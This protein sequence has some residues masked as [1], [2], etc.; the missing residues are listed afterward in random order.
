MQNPQ[1]R[2]MLLFGL[3]LGLCMVCS[4]H[5]ALA[6][7]ANTSPQ[8]FIMGYWSDWNVYSDNAAGRAIPEPAYA[9]PGSMGQSG[10]LANE[11]LQ[12]KLEKI[13]AITYDFLEVDLNGN[14]HF[15]DNWSDVRKNKQFTN[16]DKLFGDNGACTKVPAICTSYRNNDF[17]D[18]LPPEEWAKGNFQAFLNLQNTQHHLQKLISIGGYGHDNDFH[19]AFLHLGNFV[20]SVALL[21]KTTGLDGVDLDF[22]VPAPT[23]QDISDYVSLIQ[24]LRQAL[25]HHVISMAIMAGPDWIKAFG[26]RNWA[27]I[28]ENIDHIDLMTYDFH[29][30]FDTDK[31]RT[32]YLSNLY[33]DPRSSYEPGDF[34]VARSVKTLEAQG[35]PAG[36]IVVGIPAYGRALT[37]VQAEAHEGLFSTFTGIAR[38]DLDA[39]GCSMLPGGNCMG[40]FQYSYIVQHMLAKGFVAHQFN[41]TE[42]DNVVSGVWAYFP[43]RWIPDG[44]STQAYSGVF[45]SY[46][47]AAYAAALA[48]YVKANG[49]GG[50]M[51]WEL[52]GDVAPEVQGSL[53]T[54][55]A[56]NS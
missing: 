3:F 13:N 38:G 42:H 46:V 19:R 18:P 43:D 48:Q 27:I 7:S 52:R 35:V 17:N 47:D 9:I 12:K 20:A 51:M 39:P 1:F 25:P 31:N 41:D 44:Q 16:Y 6:A 34:S 4:P 33:A 26:P 37:G 45:V 56:A 22:E 49:L 11:D 23:A 14:V 15:N 54:A 28:S 53:L 8:P 30:G 29:G 10:P 2:Q 21:V 40:G 36:K 5:T 55:I 50:M 32:G 24:H